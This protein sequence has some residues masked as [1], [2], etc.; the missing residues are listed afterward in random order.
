MIVVAVAAV[1]FGAVGW[2]ALRN[3]LLGR[4]AMREAVRR[5]GQTLLV[6]GGLMIGSAAITASLIGADSSR[7]SFLLDAY[8]G[9]GNIDVTVG[10]GSRFLPEQVA[11]RLRADPEVRAASDGIAGAIQLVG[12]ASDLTTRQGEPA[13]TLVG[14]DPALQR[15]FGA[16]R[17][18]SG[19]RTYGTDLPPNGVILSK[20]LAANLRARVGD[21][22]TVQW[23]Q[24]Q[25]TGPPV[26]L[27]VAGVATSDGPGAFGLRPTVFAPLP[28]AQRISGSSGINVV[29]VSAKGGLIVGEQ[30]S[31]AAARA[32]RAGLA[33]AGANG[34]RV[35]EAKIEEVESA[36]E[37]TQFLTTMLVA[38]SMLI[39]AAGA[40]LV[41]NLITM[42][43][44]E[45]RPRYGVL[46]ALGLSRGKLIRLSIIEGAMYSLAAALIG[47]AVGILAGRVIAAR[48]AR[49]FTEFFGGETDFRFRF[50]L[51][52]ETLAVSFAAGALIT[53]VTVALAARRTSRMS[54]PAA[55]RDLPEPARERR[56][57]LVRRATLTVGTL[58]GVGL[59]LVPERFPRLIGGTAVVLVV[60]AMLKPNMSNRAYFTVLGAGLAG[61]AL[62]MTATLTD[63]SLDFT[64]FFSVFTIAVLL[65]VFGLSI[66]AA[67]NLRMVEHGI[68][69][70]GRAS[71]A[72]TRSIRV[73]LAYLARRPLR[74]G[75]TTGMFAVI[76]AILA[77]FSVFLFSFRPQ[78]ERDSA[79]YDIRVTS[80]GARSITL[81]APVRPAVAR[82]V[83]IPTLGYVGP[84]ENEQFSTGSIFLPMY[85]A[86][87]VRGVDQPVRIAQR[88]K[89]FGSDQ[90]VWR[91]LFAD[92]RAL[93]TNFI[94]PGQ[95]VTLLAPSGPVTYKVIASQ[96]FGIVDGIMG[97]PEALA[98]FGELSRGVTV[99][100]DVQSES[101]AAAVAR[102][103][104]AGLFSKGVDAEPTR[105]L[106]DE[107][108]RANKTFFSVIEILMRMGLVVGILSLGILG[109]RAVVERRHVIGVL[110]AIGY[111]KREV[112]G[113]LI[114][115]AGVTASL[116][117]LVGTF[118]GVTMGFLFIRQQSGSPDF[119]VDMGALG[120]VLLLVYLAV[121][122]VTIGPAWRASRLPP[123][124]AVRY[125]E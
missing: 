51:K 119:G 103:I 43:A 124:E 4:M 41:V 31:G 113:G 76:M 55:I 44:E 21:A 54:I 106:L 47:T 9:W 99:L 93:I 71:T 64:E 27:T 122:A 13:V 70:L 112:M 74:T 32:V 107:A 26:R 92:R 118:T 87:R 66:L 3:P 22:L 29:W 91:A 115:E 53:L 86:D 105:D 15:P 49:A 25:T 85:L 14:F 18:T 88:E 101:S 96:Q 114:A 6:I 56:R 111:Q 65:S 40:A 72:I 23:E 100:V 50:V 108:Y 24:A 110:R 48:F 60:S 90:A 20:G 11:T 30:E 120:G 81:P 98:P 73:P 77:L 69:V 57:P 19:R 61:W 17:L 123:A 95:E 52:P 121:F 16:F 125:S 62:V 34:L 102:R 97:S 45:R 10:T 68:G 8:R 36:R 82:S 2:L 38:M 117:V 94:S 35:R 1:V 89:R 58:L 46:R 39:V 42:L 67:A 83:A 7:D 5:R 37:G 80:T 79:G 63:P 116:G 59:L 109:L 78:Y 84:V 104:E 12:S 75:L 28:V 33:S